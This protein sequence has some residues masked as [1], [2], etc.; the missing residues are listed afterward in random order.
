MRDYFYP[1][2]AIATRRK[3]SGSALLSPDK[4]KTILERRRFLPSFRDWLM[5][6]RGLALQLDR[7]S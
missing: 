2:G 5:A 4:H 1:T 7:L 6:S 3:K